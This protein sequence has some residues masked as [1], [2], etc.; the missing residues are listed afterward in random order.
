MDLG[1]EEERMPFDFNY[2][3]KVGVQAAKI[4]AGNSLLSFVKISGNNKRL[5]NES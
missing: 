4:S 2:R 1:G 5:K 3:D